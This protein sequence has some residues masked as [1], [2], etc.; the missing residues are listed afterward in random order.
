MVKPLYK[1]VLL[2]LSGEVLMGDK[3]FGIDFD[4]LTSISN[5]IKTA[6]NNNIKLSI[7]IG[8]GN[9]FRGVNNK[10]FS[11]ERTDAD[12]VGMISTIINGIT[13]KNS[14]KNLDLPVVLYSALKIENVSNSYNIEEAKK[15]FEKN[16]ILIFVAGTGNPFFTTDTTAVIRG[17][18][19]DCDIILK[20]TKVDG[21][22]N[23]DPYKYNDAIKFDKLT[24]R[25]VLE[26]KLAVMDMTA[27]SLADENML[28]ILVFSIKKKN[29][30]NKV[31]HGNGS[32]TIVS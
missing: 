8:G 24:Y 13:L 4:I 3:S 27:I 19:M 23:K 2:K 17:L 5:E 25:D 9:I 29:E 14:L 12:Y 1:K 28:P 26:K 32:F 31:L 22:Y 20:A 30:L 6:Y 7:V 16:N 21:I 10:S 11:M 15:L 18:E